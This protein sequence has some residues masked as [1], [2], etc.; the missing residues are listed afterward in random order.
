MSTIELKQVSKQF[1]DGDTVIQSLKPTDFSADNG[2]FIAVIGPSG[3]GKSTFLTIVGG[4]QTP[5]E[6]E[7]I[8]N[9]TSF[10]SL[11]EKKRSKLRFE[12]IGFILQSSNLV[13]FLTIYDQFVLMDIPKSQ[14]I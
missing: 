8:I 1:Y 6:G 9:G 2:E 14:D 12:N 4:L 10:Q 5:T 7:V 13:P 11:S 3:S